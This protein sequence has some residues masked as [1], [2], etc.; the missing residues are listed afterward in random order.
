MLSIGVEGVE[1]ITI[2]F[3]PEGRKVTTSLATTILNITNKEGV[4]IR[5][6]CGGRGVCGKCR[7]IIDDQRGLNELT[8]NE[9][10]LLS[11]EEARSGYRLACCSTI[12]Q[13]SGRLTVMIPRESRLGERKF[14]TTGVE[15]L[16]KLNPSIFKCFVSL[17]RPTLQDFRPDLERLLELLRR[18]YNLDSLDL[19]YDIL[20]ALPMI[21][22]KA[23]WNVTVVIWNEHKIISIEPRDTVENVLG[24]AVDLGTSKIVTHLVDLNTSKTIAIASVENPQIIY[25][26]DVISRITFTKQNKENLRILQRLAIQ[27]I[28][29]TLDKLF[30]ETQCRPKN[31]YEAVVAGN[32]AM[33]HLFLGINPLHLALSPFTPVIRRSVKVK[34]SEL[35]I[36]MNPRGIINT[37]PIIAGFVGA[38]AIA[39]IL[40]SGIHK[41]D[42]TS[43]LMDIGTNTEVF[44]S[45]DR[46]I[47]SC[48]CA[49]G[50]AFEGAHISQ[51]MKA[52]TGA[53]EKVRIEGVSYKVDYSTIG[54]VKPVGLCGSAIID[55]ISEMLKY[56]IIE[57][58]GRFNLKIE[59]SRLRKI[60]NEVKFIIAWA[61]ETGMGKD[62]AVSGRDINEI[63][64]AKAAIFA[65]CSILMK[66]KNVDRNDLDKILIA[67]DFG[68]NINLENAKRIGLI[69]DI[70]S[71]KIEFIGNAAVVGAK[72]A[73][74]SKEAM[75]E[76]SLLS[77]TVRYLELISDTDF[78]EE[79][80][81]ALYLPHRNIEIFPSFGSRNLL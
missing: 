30:S 22:R 27:G 28:N 60:D 15:R 6:E 36:N 79:F 19:D 25:G 50:P 32:T 72:M 20:K 63:Q 16:I 4:R 49:S 42:D 46:D 10:D 69:P 52:V 58:S 12:S 34:S 21:L 38:D 77:E 33:H 59:T 26:E 14:Q 8:M 37:L 3:E 66:R 73:L 41:T 70:Q 68:S 54:G 65:G 5:S 44:V 17:T 76:T 18:E 64:L 61:E 75:E 40:A 39:D 29:E 1:K 80:I 81:N 62:I 67:G 13:H 71:E 45:S 57:T 35:K 78:K 51:G 7:V 11:P 48:S 56:G 31:I 24:L 23:D 9:V 74:I 2:I 43:L 55:V 47:L 53:I